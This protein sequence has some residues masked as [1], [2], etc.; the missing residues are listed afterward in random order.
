MDAGSFGFV[1][2]MDIVLRCP[3]GAGILN[4]AL[5]ILFHHDDAT[6]FDLHEAQAIS[7]H[8]PAGL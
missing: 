8:L 4:C 2:C 6:E 7:I 3:V 5:M 1:E